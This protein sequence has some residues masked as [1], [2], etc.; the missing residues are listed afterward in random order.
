MSLQDPRLDLPASALSDPTERFALVYARART[1]DPKFHDAMCLATVG[2]DGRPSARMV[3][4]KAFD[5][6][7]FV[8]F[9]NL[10]SRKGGEL[11][12]HPHVSLCFHWSTM[13]EQVR[14]EGR[15]EPV[16]DAEADA[17][18]ASR[19]RGSQIGAWASP[20]SQRIAGREELE[21]RIAEVESRFGDGLVPRP[22]HWSGLRVVPD[23]I[24][25]WVGMPSRLHHRQAYT[26]DGSLWRVETL[27]P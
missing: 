26:R 2:P 24:E 15:A 6:R 27:A 4:L 25:F 10:T 23:R 18:F 12:A 3:L 16:S 7:G 21:A 20:Q 19:P 5:A 9:T 17:Y 13:E 14:I 1:A 11:A 8:F 22:P